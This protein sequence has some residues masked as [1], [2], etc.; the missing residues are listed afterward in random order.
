MVL[1][2]P[3]C[4]SPKCTALEDALQ[5]LSRI[6]I[7]IF[8]A[9]VEHPSCL[10]TFLSYNHQETPMGRIKNKVAKVRVPR[11]AIKIDVEKLA[12]SHKRQIL[13]IGSII[14]YVLGNFELLAAFIL[15]WVS[16]FIVESKS[17]DFG[18]DVFGIE[19]TTLASV[20]IGMN[21]SPAFTFLY[22]YLT[23]ALIYGIDEFVDPD[24]DELANP[25]GAYSLGFGMAGLFAAYFSS[26]LSFVPLMICA[27]LVANI[28][29]V[30]FDLFVE[31]EFVLTLTLVSNVFFNGLVGFLIATL[32]T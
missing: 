32:L 14:S 28:T 2:S 27:A 6:F 3:S 25:F 10:Q 26:V 4:G 20:W 11:R 21:F 30:L 16:Y 13:A 7:K 18:I 15:M 5:N 23:I 31:R 19:L 12:F 1:S 22:V 24:K 9:G 8:K 17:E 29:R